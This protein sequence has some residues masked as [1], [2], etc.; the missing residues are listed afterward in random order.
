[1]IPSKYLQFA[2]DTAKEAGEILMKHYAKT[3]NITYKSVHNLVTDADKASEKFIITNIKKHFPDHGIVSE[4]SGITNANKKIRWFIDPLDGTTNFAHSFTAF[5]VVIALEINQKT[6]IGVVYNPCLKELFTAERG[7]GAYLNGKKI[8][9]SKTPDLDHSLL[10]TGFSPAYAAK[11]M[12]YFRTLMPLCHGVRRMGA[13]AI[14]LCYTACGRFD[15]YWE[16]GLYPWD[17]AAGALIVEEAGGKA[18]N[19]DGSP[20]S[21]FKKNILSSNKRIHGELLQ[22]FKEHPLPKL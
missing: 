3:L 15:G 19:C 12:K 4:E 6:E 13:A 9:V 20:L 21:L 18:T 10:A 14:D 22:I 16:F 11:N 2:I 7:K 8:H 5:A 17:I 1:M